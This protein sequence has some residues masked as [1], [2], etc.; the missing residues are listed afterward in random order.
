MG[1]P[2]AKP[3]RGRDR[4]GTYL[5]TQSDRI[6]RLGDHFRQ[7]DASR[8]PPAA[9]WR[10]VRLPSDKHPWRETYSPGGGWG[11]TAAGVRRWP[12]VRTIER[13]RVAGPVP[14]AWRR[15]CDA[16][17][18]PAPVAAAGRGDSAGRG[19]G[20]RAAWRGRAT[21]CRRHRGGTDQQRVTACAVTNRWRGR[22]ARGRGAVTAG[23]GERSQV[24][25]GG[26]N[27]VSLFPAPAWR[28]M[29]AGA[30]GIAASCAPGIEGIGDASGVETCRRRA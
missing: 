28:P 29:A 21:G 9:C 23:K 14:G 25:A 3:P 15:G 8:T 30:A 4:E 18:D 27:P 13:G 6:G 1:T 5:R 22:P 26:T 2:A 17:R 11:A 7:C 12:D 24:L 16:G 19:V 10:P 20:F